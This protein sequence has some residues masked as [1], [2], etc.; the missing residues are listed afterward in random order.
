MTQADYVK[1]LCD[2]L[3]KDVGLAIESAVHEE[4]ERIIAVIV[5]LGLVD[6]SNQLRAALVFAIAK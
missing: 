2:T 3:A 1:V 4:R 6:D 5:G